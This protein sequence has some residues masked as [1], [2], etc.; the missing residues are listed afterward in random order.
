MAR[1]GSRRPRRP[2]SSSTT[3]T[4]S[5]RNAAGRSGARASILHTDDGGDDLGR[6]R[7]AASTSTSS[8]STSSTPSTASPSATGASSSPPAT[9]ASTWED[10][11]LTDDVIL[12]DVSMVDATHGWIAGEI[13]TVLTHRGRRRA[14]GRTQATGVDKTLFGVYF[15]DAQHG[16]VVGIDALILRTDGRW[17]DLEGAERL[18]RDPRARAGGVRSGVREPEPVRRAGRRRPGRRRGRD[19]R[20]LHSAADGGRTWTRRPGDGKTVGP[21]WFRAVSLVPG[22]HGVIVGA[23]GE[24][25]RVVDG[26][27]ESA[28]RGDTCC[29]NSSLKRTCTS[30]CATACRSPRSSPSSPRSSSGSRRRT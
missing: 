7:R 15:A 18:D 16:W 3:S 8:A 24:R 27:V 23:D 2:P 17:A 21:K 12:N 29:R 14:P 19:R 22:T 10:H 30:C 20:G 28:R 13:G 26:R 5:T 4:S 25:L 1:P 6:R 9:A 11:S